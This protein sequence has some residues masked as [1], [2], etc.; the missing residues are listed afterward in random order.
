MNITYEFDPYED[1]DELKI[2]QK[3]H[4]YH[5]ALWDITTALRN[6]EKHQYPGDDASCEERMASMQQLIAT[7]ESSCVGLGIWED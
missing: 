5:T 6:W 1:R 7:I 3:A 4:D 2:F